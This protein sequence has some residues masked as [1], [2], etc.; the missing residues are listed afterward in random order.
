MGADPG[1]IRD[2]D[3]GRWTALIDEALASVVAETETTL[4]GATS[5]ADAGK[6]AAASHVQQ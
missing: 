5:R 2:R 3:P 4:P 1:L 6:A